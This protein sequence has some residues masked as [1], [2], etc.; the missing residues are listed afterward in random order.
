[1]ENIHYPHM[2]SLKDIPEF[3]R[4]VQNN[5]GKKID[6]QDTAITYGLAINWM[7]ILDILWPPFDKIDFYMVEVKY[8]VYN[9]PDNK[10]LPDAFFQHIQDV[11][12]FFWTSQLQELYPDGGYIIESDHNC[13][14]L[15]QVTIKKNQIK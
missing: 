3:Q 15:I 2:F 11:L 6:E 10:D 12:R 9:D 8:L 5:P 4:F 14:Y 13:E 1:M 7:S